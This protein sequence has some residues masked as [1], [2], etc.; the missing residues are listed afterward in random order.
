MR[1]AG[2]GEGT[3]GS[4]DAKLIGNIRCKDTPGHKDREDCSKRLLQENFL[5]TEGNRLDVYLKFIPL[6]LLQLQAI[7]DC[8][9]FMKSKTIKIVLRDTLTSI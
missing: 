9:D 5:A 4:Y 7:E 8:D 6:E 2:D 1:S 3:V